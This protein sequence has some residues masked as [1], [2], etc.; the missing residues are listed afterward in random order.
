V[1]SYDLAVALFGFAP[2]FG[3][4]TGFRAAQEVGVALDSVEFVG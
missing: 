3:A 4:V 2:G 1:F